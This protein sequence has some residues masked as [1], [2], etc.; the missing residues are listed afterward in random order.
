MKSPLPRYETTWD[1]SRITDYLSTLFPLPKLTL[2]LLTLKTAALCALVSYQREP[3]LC[4]LDL[5]NFVTT[6][7]AG[8]FYITKRFHGQASSLTRTFRPFRAIQAYWIAP[9]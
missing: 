2:K 3:T 9:S 1:V 5:N 8:K 7:D 4:S 6:P